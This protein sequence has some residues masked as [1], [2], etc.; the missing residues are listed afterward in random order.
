MAQ[1]LAT[2]AGGALLDVGRSL[3]S[4]PVLAYGLVFTLEAVGL[5]LAVFMLRRVNVVEF[6]TNTRQAISQ[7]LA[8]GLD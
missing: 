1:A 7:V 4:E 6:R 8:Q 2:L 3:F 5:V